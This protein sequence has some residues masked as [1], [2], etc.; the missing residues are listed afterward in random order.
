MSDD[1]PADAAPDNFDATLDEI[2]VVNFIGKRPRSQDEID[3]YRDRYGIE[4]PAGAMTG[5]NDPTSE[6]VAALIGDVMHIGVAEPAPG[7]KRTPL[8]SSRSRHR[9]FRKK[10]AGVWHRKVMLPTTGAA[11]RKTGKSAAF[12]A[13]ARLTGD[14]LRDRVRTLA[15]ALRVD[16]SKRELAGAV[17]A[18]INAGMAEGDK[19]VTVGNI[20]RV[21]ARLKTS[22]SK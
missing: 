22:A 4:F 6:Q 1:N 8:V 21:L 3:W 10:I 2:K 19:P 9:I 15:N 18:K 20:R 16:F 12:V 5:G 11:A 17:T 7:K 14:V 13:Q